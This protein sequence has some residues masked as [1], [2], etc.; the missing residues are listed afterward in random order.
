M[1]TGRPR[2]PTSLSFPEGRDAFFSAGA[3]GPAYGHLSL[4]GSA[5]PRG[6]TFRHP[7]RVP[8]RRPDVVGLGESSPSGLGGNSQL[9]RGVVYSPRHW[10]SYGPGPSLWTL[11]RGRLRVAC[12]RSRRTHLRDPSTSSGLNPDPNLHG[13]LGREVGTSRL[14]GEEPER[15]VDPVP[16]PKTRKTH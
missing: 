11:Y 1:G 3:L 9:T 14:R 7:R 16:T 10:F 15:T 4:L 5:T 6:V 2:R 8:K 13:G 12:H